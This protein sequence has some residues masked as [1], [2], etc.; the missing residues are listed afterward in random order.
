[1]HKVVGPFRRATSASR[2]AYIHQRRY[3]S[4]LLAPVQALDEEKFGCFSARASV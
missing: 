2:S 4:A 3:I 1:M